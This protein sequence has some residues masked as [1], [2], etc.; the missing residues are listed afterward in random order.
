MNP[1]AKNIPL[2]HHKNPI[3]SARVVDS[4]KVDWG[5][6]KCINI[7][8]KLVKKSQ[9]LKKP[10]SDESSD[11]DE[12]N[13]ESNDPEKELEKAKNDIIERRNQLLY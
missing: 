2:P 9:K 6:Y 8:K 3:S 4:D 7:A 13:S 10:E 1:F 12:S 5:A 11:S